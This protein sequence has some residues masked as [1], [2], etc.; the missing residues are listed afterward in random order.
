MAPSKERH[1]LE[2][3]NGERRR[4]ERGWRAEEMGGM[5]KGGNHPA[6]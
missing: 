2:L 3:V 1:W 5:V 6:F 4:R